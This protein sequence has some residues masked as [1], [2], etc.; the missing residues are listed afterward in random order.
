M[1]ISHTH[2]HKHSSRFR[3]FQVLVCRSHSKRGN[4]AEIKRKKPRGP[5]DTERPQQRQSKGRRFDV[6]SPVGVHPLFLP[7]LFLPHSLPPALYPPP[8]SSSLSAALC[9]LFGLLGAYQAHRSMSPSNAAFILSLPWQLPISPKESAG[10]VFPWRWHGDIARRLWTA[11]RDSV[12]FLLSSSHPA[13]PS[14]S[15]FA[16][17]FASLLL[18]IWRQPSHP[19]S[20]QLFEGACAWVCKHARLCTTDGKFSCLWVYLP[21]SMSPK[22]GE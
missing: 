13:L 4:E 19:W 17:P 5:A 15:L 18:L 2:T 8:P 11:C 14:V 22:R 6:A 3:L 10:S 1:N 12:P 20:L 16:H 9:W 21:V 7:S